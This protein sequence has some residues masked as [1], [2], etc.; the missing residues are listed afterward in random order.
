MRSMWRFLI[1]TGHPQV[2]NADLAEASFSTMDKSTLRKMEAALVKMLLLSEESAD[3][4][5]DASS[6]R[7]VTGD[8]IFLTSSEAV[9]E[10]SPPKAIANAPAVDQL[11][12]SFSDESADQKRVSKASDKGRAQRPESREI[13]DPFSDLKAAFEP[14]KEKLNLQQEP[15]CNSE[16]H[17]AYEHA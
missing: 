3:G 11:K 4:G 12:A 15:N 17:S 6:V 1:E 9:A 14:P 2:R 16:W 8:L 7:A 5:H 13:R 10:S